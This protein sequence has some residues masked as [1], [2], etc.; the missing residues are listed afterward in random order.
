VTRKR[1]TRKIPKKSRKKPAKRPPKKIKPLMIV[2]GD[3]HGELEG[4]IQILR[5]SR[6]V[7]KSLNWKAKNR[8]LVQMGD[9][10]D[11]GE[12]GIEVFDMLGKLALQARKFKSKVVRLIGN[13]EF[14]ILRGN[15]YLTNIAQDEILT[16]RKKLISDVLNKRI[17]S[18]FSYKGFLFTH[19]G[20]CDGLLAELSHRLLP[21]KPTAKNIADL[22][23][24]TVIKGVFKGDF[25][26]PVFNISPFRGGMD[27][28]G[29]I[30][31]EDFRDLILSEHKH[32][33]V[34]IVGH[35]PLTKITYSPNGKV[36]AT[37]IGIC[38]MYGAGRAYLEIRDAKVKIV[39]L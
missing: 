18:A 32:S 7:D 14:E 15:Y 9:V 39:N 20:I 31:W 8:I 4:F 28:Y 10:I 21:K 16:F 25:K 12:F 1:K 35:T 3:I 37:D 36:I 11:R 22:I 17:I 2:V 33:F 27:E 26:N 13:H 23:N 24:S 34:Q 30:F 6:I 19:A 29:G 5:H 38:K